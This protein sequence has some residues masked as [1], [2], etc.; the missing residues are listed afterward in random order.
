MATAADDK[1][2]KLAIRQEAL[3]ASMHALLDVT[4]QTR[5][6]VAELAVWLQQP[7]SNDLPDLL[8]AMTLAVQAN[9][10]AIVTLGRRVEA[11]PAELEKAIRG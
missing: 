9:T 11:L 1:L 4:K 2:D 6:M 8:K 7:P 10:E 5:D 3:V